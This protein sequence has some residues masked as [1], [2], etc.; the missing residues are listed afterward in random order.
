MEVNIETIKASYRKYPLAWWA[1]GISIVLGLILY[2]RMPLMEQTRDA[3][4][5]VQEDLAV[6]QMN[7]RE[8]S[9]MTED[10]EHIEDLIK[11]FQSR[12]TDSSQRARNIGYFDGFPGLFSGRLKSLQLTSI[13]QMQSIAEKANLVGAD[14]WGMRNYSV[15]PF[16]MTASGLLTE[17]LDFLYL[18][19]QGSVILNVRSFELSTDNRREQGYMTMRFTVNTVAN[20]V[21]NK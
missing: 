17:I 20:P 16:E 18:L 6:I 15:L 21:A 7:F 11:S 19:K 13:N 10:L 4:L 12:L 2:V 3:L 5:L 9:G 14:I 8:G 1:C